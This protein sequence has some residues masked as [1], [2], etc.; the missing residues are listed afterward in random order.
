MA[1]PETQDPDIG[2][3]AERAL[4]PIAAG[5]ILDCVDLA[6]FGPVGLFLGPIVG[7]V[8]GW[9]L[10]GAAQLPEKWRLPAAILS[11]VYCM[12]PGTEIIPVATIIG[13]L[14]RFWGPSVPDK[15]N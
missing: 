12:T 7:G 9:Y 14:S 11:G 3:R 10:A 15:K 13:A 4:G 1:G 5:M 8:V 6:T 2:K